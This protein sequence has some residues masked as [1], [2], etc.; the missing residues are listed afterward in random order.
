MVVVDEVVDIFDESAV[1]Q[2]IAT[3]FQAHQDLCLIPWAWTSPMDPSSYGLTAPYS[4]E[5]L[6]TKVGFDATKPFGILFP[7]RTGLPKEIMEK[8][9]LSEYLK[10]GF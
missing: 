6:V 9:Q 8:I 5:G 4:G 7:E 2:A 3:R 10:D 1:L